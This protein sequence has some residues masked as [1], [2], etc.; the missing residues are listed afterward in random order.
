[1][2]DAGL[3]S[4]SAIDL[5]D[6]LSN[7]TGIQMP[8]TIVFDYPCVSDLAEK[9][10]SLQTKEELSS[11][12]CSANCDNH[13]LDNYINIHP[14][15]CVLAVAAHF[16]GSSNSCDMISR[17]P[18]ERWDA[19]DSQDGRAAPEFGAFLGELDNFDAS[20]FD[21]SMS[22]LALLDAQQRMLLVSSSE[23]LQQSEL[24]T[25]ECNA[26]G[27]YVGISSMDHQTLVNRKMVSISPFAATGGALSVAAG[28]L[29]FVHG[30]SGASVSID[31]ACSS[32]LVALQ[33]AMS[34]TV[35]SC[36]SKN[37]S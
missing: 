25:E 16:P 11:S 18:L 35:T 10:A 24:S 2:I 36:L 22:E 20:F 28:R 8:A 32:S 9:V 37:F 26:T 6:A 7:E 31:T 21:I 34:A 13:S 23:S 29:S 1:M 4:L 19:R 33:V 12:F 3:D 15:L 5:R 27:V 17:T 30:L 14:K